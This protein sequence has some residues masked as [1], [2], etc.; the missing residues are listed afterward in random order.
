MSAVCIPV[1]ALTGCANGGGTR[2]TETLPTTATETAPS[3]TADAETQP[4]SPA[5]NT[6]PAT[7]TGDVTPDDPATYFDNVTPL[8]DA[9]REQ[10]GDIEVSGLLVYSDQAL[11]THKDPATPIRTL[12]HVY[13]DG[14]WT[15]R[16]QIPYSITGTTLS[17]DQIDPE[18]LRAAARDAPVEL[19]AEDAEVDHVSIGTEDD[20]TQ[21]YV[22]SLHT[23][24]SVGSVTYGS[25]DEVLEVTSP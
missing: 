3:T 13:R 2:A 18:R 5:A 6:S 1:L 10:L 19:G 24:D 8:L 16:F 12:R 11:L 21:V 22:V 25:D 7:D 23:D 9:A 15:D 20:G 4:G 17:L 14:T